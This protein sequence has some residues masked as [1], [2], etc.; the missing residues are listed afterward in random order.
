MLSL[1]GAYTVTKGL[2]LN[3]AADY[4]IVKNKGNDAAVNAS[5]FQLTLGLKYSI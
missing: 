5:D 2:D 1:T 4:L 3:L